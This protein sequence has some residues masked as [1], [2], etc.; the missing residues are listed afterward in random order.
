MSSQFEP[1]QAPPRLGQQPPQGQDQNALDQNAPGRAGAGPADPDSRQAS[2]GA[3]TRGATVIVRGEAVREPD[4]KGV[5]QDSA[6][7]NLRES[8]PRKVSE[9]AESRRK[10]LPA[11]ADDAEVGV[12]KKQR[13]VRDGKPDLAFE[14]TLLASAAPQGAPEGHWDEYRI[15]ATDGGKHVFS[16]VSRNIL[17]EEQDRHEADVFDPSPSS[18]PSQLIRSARELARSRP[19]TWADAAVAFFGYDPL[20]KDLYRKF[21]DQFDEQIS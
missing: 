5:P 13:V 20:A 4:S 1:S 9:E 18:V 10:R 17:I 6:A 8:A 12:Q 21:G 16:K 15:Y 19:M 2:G 11:L 7:K 3:A 14:G